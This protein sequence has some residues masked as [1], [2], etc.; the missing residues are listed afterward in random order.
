MAALRFRRRAGG[1]Q[2]APASP[3]RPVAENAG[4]IGDRAEANRAGDAGLTSAAGR[5]PDLDLDLDLDMPD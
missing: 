4:M 1:A 3:H 2:P 5:R